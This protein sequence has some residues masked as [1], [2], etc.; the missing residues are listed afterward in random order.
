MAAEKIYKDPGSRQQ[1]AGEPVKMPGIFGGETEKSPGDSL[2]KG[3]IFWYHSG[4][5]NF[6]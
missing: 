5:S 2:E 3:G 4:N 1:N 6:Y